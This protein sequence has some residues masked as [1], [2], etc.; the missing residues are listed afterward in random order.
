MAR[1]TACNYPPVISWDV[2][3]VV[4]EHWVR[5]ARVLLHVRDRYAGV[6]HG[7]RAYGH[8][9]SPTCSSRRTSMSAR[10]YLQLVPAKRQFL[11]ERALRDVQLH[12]F[13]S[14]QRQYAL[15]ARAIELGFAREQV[16][17]IDEGPGYLRLGGCLSARGSRIGRR[18]S[19]SGTPGWCSVWRSPDWRATTPTPRRRRR[20]RR[21]DLSP[22]LVQRPA[23]AEQE[24]VVERAGV[25][26]PILVTDQRAR[27]GAQLQQSVPISVSCRP[28]AYADLGSELPAKSGIESRGGRH[29][30]AGLIEGSS[31]C[32]QREER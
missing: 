17:V 24:A 15:V 12:E 25:I 4:L 16:V 14:T 28:C 2:R 8:G 30:R 3:H 20:R 32:D 9:R 27:Q 19:R 23:A 29:N 18:R 11:A 13:E 5:A 21:R 7:G 31:L 6:V 10:R 1:Q 26:D 22:R